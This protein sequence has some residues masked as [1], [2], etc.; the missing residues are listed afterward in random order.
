MPWSCHR[1]I[2][3]TTIMSV[4]RVIY[5]VSNTSIVRCPGGG[6]REKDEGECPK[7]LRKYTAITHPDAH[8]S[9][10]WQRHITWQLNLD[11]FFIFFP[12]PS[13]CVCVCAQSLISHVVMKS[14][15]WVM[16]LIRNTCYRL[17]KFL[18]SLNVRKKIS[19]ECHKYV[20]YCRQTRGY[21][22]C[23]TVQN[24]SGFRQPNFQLHVYRYACSSPQRHTRVI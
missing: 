4:H 15:D 2:V 14:T 7:L 18:V 22:Q 23:H 24:V 10:L 13:V 8:L 5:Y 9:P 21:P 11:S 20:F 12:F 19:M 6:G 16:L 1:I 17:P 3:T